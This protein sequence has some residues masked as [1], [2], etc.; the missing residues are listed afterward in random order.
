MRSA[1]Y[2]L[3]KSSLHLAEIG[4]VDPVFGKKNFKNKYGRKKVC[5]PEFFQS[6]Q[7]FGLHNKTIA[8]NKT[9]L[10]ILGLQSLRDDNW[11]VV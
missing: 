2:R 6:S 9:V 3:N 7:S 1:I 4:F 8:R 10:E 11:P 5:G